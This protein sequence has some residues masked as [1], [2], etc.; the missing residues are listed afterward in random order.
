[1]EPNSLNPVIQTLD[2]S[3]LKGGF[4]RELATA[5]LD[6]I[7]CSPYKRHL[8]LSGLENGLPQNEE[9]ALR[10][11]LRLRLLFVDEPEPSEALLDKLSG[12]C[13]LYQLVQDYLA[14]PTDPAEFETRCNA[15]RRSRPSEE[16]SLMAH[17]LTYQLAVYDASEP[18][19][20]RERQTNIA[21]ACSD[22]LHRLERH[23]RSLFG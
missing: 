15:L 21:V 12:L 17:S 19:A 13:L 22:L 18:A 11:L 5:C 8:V 9:Q 4:S 3:L 20:L 6:R 2:E 10:A 14:H 1:M 16:I 23:W 7:A